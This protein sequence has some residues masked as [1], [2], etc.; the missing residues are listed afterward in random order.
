MNT[1]TTTCEA[2]GSMARCQ[3]LVRPALRAAVGSLGGEL[4]VMCGFAL[5]WWDSDGRPGK[6]GAGKGLRPALALLGARTA[7]VPAETAVAGAVAV[8]LMHVF[9]LV[10]DDIMDGDEQ[11]RH[12]PSVW[13]AYGVGP[14]VLTGDAL[15]A[16][17]LRTLA[18]VP[19]NGSAEATR[20]LSGALVDLVGGQA[21]D[22]AFESRP[23]TGPRAVT[24]AEYRRMAARK[25]GALLGCSIAIGAALAGAPA[26]VVTGLQEAGRHLGLAFQ[27]IDDVLGIWGDPAV[28]G[29]PAF[30]DL[31]SGKKTAP[32]LAAL[33][34]PPADPLPGPRTGPDRGGRLVALLSGGRDDAQVRQA[35]ELIEATGGRA[36]AEQMACHYQ[37][38][39]IRELRALDTDGSADELIAV[40]RLLTDRLS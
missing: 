22:L 11:R 36:V 35:A 12:R 1:P 13:K 6:G 24:M 4:E 8:E 5:G 16:L 10:H 23:W 30:S 21:A 38:A 26:A 3:E 19:H 31:R 17:A 9:S 28:T 18:D 15:L 37:D 14:A 32:V 25:T 29:K 40:A 2:T 34:G 7:G 33:T 20:L 27:A 39:A